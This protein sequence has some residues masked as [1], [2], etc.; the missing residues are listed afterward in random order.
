MA[1]VDFDDGTAGFEGG[2]H[3]VVFDIEVGGAGEESAGFEGGEGVFQQAV[4]GFRVVPV[5]LVADEDE[6]HGREFA[7]A[8]GGGG[9]AGEEGDFAI[10]QVPAFL[11]FCD[12]FGAEVDSEVEADGFGAEGIGECAGFVGA[13]AGEIE[14]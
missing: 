6:V 7:H 11:C 8:V 13:A 5:V 4:P 10:G 1:D 2:H 3:E 9:V 12:G 14:D